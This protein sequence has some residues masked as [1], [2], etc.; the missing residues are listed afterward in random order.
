LILGAVCAVVIGVFVWSATSGLLEARAARAKD[1]YYN[2]LVQGL[3]AG[4]L[5]LKSEAPPGLAQL[6]D[7]YDPIAN[8][9]YR[10]ADRYPL[11]DLSFYRGKLYL[12]FGI[13][14][15]LLLFWPY[16]ALTGQYLL[17]KDAVVVFCAV[18]FLASAGLLWAIWRR[19][20]AEVS[21][22]VV[23]AGT[24][25]LGLASFMP[26]I[27][28]RCDVYE[29]SISCGYAL[30]MLALA[31]IWRALHEPGRRGWWLA[32]ASLAYGLALGARP[33]L[34]FG[35]VILL[36]PAAHARREKA[37]PDSPRRLWALVVAATAPLLLIALGLLLYNTLRFGHPLEFGQRYMLAAYREDKVQHFS[38]SYLWFNL[39]LYC[40]EPARW[41]GRFPFAHDAAVPPPPAGHGGVDHPFGLLTNIPVVWLALA[42]PLAC[43]RRSGE[44]RSTLN[45]FLAALVL[46]FGTSALTIGLYYAVCLRYQADFVPELVLLA[47]IGILAV[48]RALAG[49]LV[50]RLAACCGWG[51]LLAFSVLFNLLASLD[52]LAETYAGLGNLQL[53]AGQL[54]QAMA[55][56][57]RA[58]QFSP[59]NASTHSDLGIALFRKGQVD[60][61]IAQFR[62]A[63][64]LQP[65]ATE[66]HSN[67]G[68]ALVRKGQVD[69]AIVEFRKAGE[70]QPNDAAVQN[71]LARLLRQQGLADEALVHFQKAVQMDPTLVSAHRNLGD[72]LL[73]KGAVD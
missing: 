56:F 31:G 45:W 64:A 16:A 48:A 26:L 5:N 8:S 59:D 27:L 46:L 24:L 4:Q 38:L 50:W 10:L 39:R 12:Y 33:S 14:P 53:D 19:Y 51:L 62:K 3:R 41:S 57:Q 30:T 42:V 2:L 13:T 71:S 11:H 29:V 15:A 35:G 67:L 54:D 55:L 66:G 60:E 47:A 18:G 6:A 21:L 61:A 58:L 43:R 34:L 17:H 63:V 40:L 52:R 44:A 23:A 1:T 73:Q 70:L 49:R 9:D 65:A 36:V 25:A 68:N 32:A 37:E 28:P 20:F 22:G 69:E 72:L 7:P